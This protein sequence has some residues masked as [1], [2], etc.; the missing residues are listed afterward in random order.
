MIESRN[1]VLKDS[2][3]RLCQSRNRRKRDPSLRRLRSEWRIPALF[4][5]AGWANADLLR[6]QLMLAG[7]LSALSLRRVRSSL[8]E[9]N[10]MAKAIP[11]H[12]RHVFLSWLEVVLQGQLDDSVTLFLGG[13]TEVRVGLR[14]SAGRRVLS[15]A[16][17]EVV[18]VERPERVVQP[19]V[20]ANPELQALVFGDLKVLEQGHVPTEER[21]SINGR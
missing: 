3:V 6:E 10:G 17:P 1:W 7:F 5:N 21:R 9:R 4:N 11:F 15:E 16:E 8:Q 13:D 14:Y 18:S 19:V 2:A 20:A 12:P